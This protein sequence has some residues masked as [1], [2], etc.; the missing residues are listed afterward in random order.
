MKQKIQR[1][2]HFLSRIVMPNIGAFIAWGLISALFIEDGWIPNPV[3]A[4]IQPYLLSYLLPILLAMQG[5]KLTGGKR[6]QLAAA[7][8][9]MGCIASVGGENGSPVL[10]H[11]MLMGAVAGWCMQGFDRLIDGHIPAGFEMLVQNL[12]LGMISTFLTVVGYY[13]TAPI[14]SA[15]QV[16]L[17]A[18]LNIIVNRGLLPLSALFIEPAKVLF[19]N[20]A[21]NHGVFTPIGAEQVNQAGKSIMYMLETNPGPGLGVLLAY[22]V[23]S[24]DDTLKHAAPSAILIQFF[25]G[26]HEIYFPYILTNPIVIVAPIVGNLCAIT[27]YSVFQCG[28]VGPPSPGS[29]IAFLTMS[30]R[31]QIGLTLAGIVLAAGVSFL[32]AAPIIRWHKEKQ[33]KAMSKPSI[34]VPHALTKIVFACDA[35]MGSSVMGAADFRRRLAQLRPDLTILNSSVEEI[36]PDADLV[37]CQKALADRA[38]AA[39]P[40]AHLLPV[41]RFFA[42]PELEQLC[43][44]LTHQTVSPPPTETAVSQEFLRRE[45]IR[46]RLPSV[47]R[48]EAIQAAGTL[49]WELGYTEQGYT[50]AM[51]EREALVSTYMGMGTAIPHGTAQSRELIHH[52][53]MVLLQYPDG[54]DF[55]GETVYLVFGIAGKGE[56]HLELLSKICS[57][58]EKEE[59]LEEMRHS[60]DPEFLKKQ[61]E[62]SQ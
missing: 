51:L 41:N 44:Q 15:F 21:V 30:P 1:L 38:A 6:G 4:S 18:A 3:L 2:G 14:I 23:F 26:I 10:L 57:V 35:G 46:T 32:A 54:I 33:P 56:E 60:N 55:E 36:P 17:T 11:A 13:L 49:L 40:K 47:S 22:W 34:P 58:L 16:C 50:A 9:V 8:A 52:S 5:G 37:I 29:V 28:L 7:V 53:G 43:Q 42:D 24:K 45:G 25:G 39:A 12:S 31:S 19:L 59:I 61:F 62:S 20:N 27:F 48:E